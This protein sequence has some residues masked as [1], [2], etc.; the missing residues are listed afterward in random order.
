MVARMTSEE[1]AIKPIEGSKPKAGMNHEITLEMTMESEEALTVKSS[2]HVHTR[3]G[4]VLDS[5]DQT[6]METLEQLVPVGIED[7]ACVSSR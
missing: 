6:F 2:V 7:D 1:P 4:Q 3:H 5:V